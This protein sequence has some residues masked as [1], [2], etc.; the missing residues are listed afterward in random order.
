MTDCKTIGI[1][2]LAVDLLKRNTRVYV[3]ANKLNKIPDAVDS[4]QPARTTRRRQAWQ[5]AQIRIMEGIDS[6]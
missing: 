1:L 2:S 4:E 3:E 6:F 5:Q